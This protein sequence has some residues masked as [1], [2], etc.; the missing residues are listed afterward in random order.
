MR[1][2]VNEKHGYQLGAS[3]IRSIIGQLTSLD[4]VRPMRVFARVEELLM[5]RNWP[6]LSMV[7]LGRGSGTPSCPTGRSAAPTAPAASTSPTRTSC[8]GRSP[9]IPRT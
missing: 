7:D 4:A 3:A 6:V 2:I 8:G 1:G 5:R 9:A